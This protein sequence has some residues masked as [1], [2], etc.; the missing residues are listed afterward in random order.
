MASCQPHPERARLG[1]RYTTPRDASPRT[2]RSTIRRHNRRKGPFRTFQ[3]A[4]YRPAM[5]SAGGSVS[6]T[7]NGHIRRWPGTRRPCPW[8]WCD[9]LVIRAGRGVGRGPAGGVHPA[10]CPI[11]PGGL[12]WPAGRCDPR[13]GFGTR[14]TTGGGAPRQGCVYNIVQPVRVV[15]ISAG[16]QRGVRLGSHVRTAATRERW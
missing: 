1:P 14:G 11:I 3:A 4:T 6:T 10:G 12:G 16:R 8:E 13:A 7:R 5:S 15:A 2:T 9:A